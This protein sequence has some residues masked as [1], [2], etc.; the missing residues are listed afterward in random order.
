MQTVNLKNHNVIMSRTVTAIILFLTLALQGSWAVPAYRGKISY[1]QPDGSRVTVYLRGD[2]YSHFYESEDGA[3]L[4]RDNAG[5]LCYATLD[6][7]GEPVASAFQATD[8][9]RRSAAAQSYISSQDRRTILRALSAKGDKARAARR[10]P[11]TY[12]R[13]FPTTGVVTGLVILAEYQDVKFAEGHTREMYDELANAE[14]YQGDYATGSVHDYF[15]AQSYGEFT[16]RFDVVGPVT[17]PHDMKYYGTD[18]L[19]AEM[20]IDACNE[21]K[22]T[23]DVDFSKYDADGDGNVDFVFVIYAGY[24]EAQGGP[25][26]SVWPQ[27]V[28]L[29]YESW[30]TYDGLFLVNAA[31]TCELHGNEGTEP[32]G[33]GTFCHE[34][35]HILGL[36]DV[37]DTSAGGSS[38]GMSDWD[39]MD[40]GTYLDNGRTP[41]GYTAMDKYS[42]GWIQPIVIKDAASDLTLRPLSESKEAYFIVCE[43]NENEYYTLENRQNTG[44]DIALPGHGLLITHVHY[45]PSLWSSNRVNASSGGYEHISLVPADNNKSATSFA[46][47][48]FPGSKSITEFTDTTNPAASWYT[49]DEPVNSPVTNIREENGIIKFDFKQGSTAIDETVSTPSQLKIMSI[50]GALHIGNPQGKTVTVTTTDGRVICRSAA[51]EQSLQPGNGIYIV[52]CEGISNKIAI[53]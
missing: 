43:G 45:V 24:G 13:K 3:V 25:Y 32:D 35:S 39:I 31:C 22:A 47:D 17:L 27:K 21:A 49:T 26:Q 18:E 42:V 30:N 2:E 23:T 16:P 1:T 14:N 6:A 4:L 9:S 36:P 44:W 48:P 52:S 15:V 53:K 7:S 12:T 33:I 29:T 5:S 41:A 10:A 19:V 37:Y 40:H 20:I 8:I 28:D 38:F 34:F 11:G 51:T 46:G 50:A